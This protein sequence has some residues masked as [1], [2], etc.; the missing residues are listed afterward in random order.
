M[1]AIA[2]P[3]LFEPGAVVVSLKGHDRGRLYLVLAQR[4]VTRLLLA[5]GRS[6]GYVDAKLKNTRHVKKLG[7]AASAEAVEEILGDCENDCR[8]AIRRLIADWESGK[9][10]VDGQGTKAIGGEDAERRSN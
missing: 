6:H 9:L 7:Q 2:L 10:S 8:A 3:P 1:I 4:G 5:D